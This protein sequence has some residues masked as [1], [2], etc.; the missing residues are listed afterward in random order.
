MLL[1][2]KATGRTSLHPDDRFYLEVRF[3]A[4]GEGQDPSLDYMYVSRLWTAG[5]ALDE[6][7]AIVYY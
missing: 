6:V 4:M 7:S 2:T 3:G 5:R 1:K